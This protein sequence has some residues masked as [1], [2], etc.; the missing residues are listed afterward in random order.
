MAVRVRGAKELYRVRTIAGKA[1]VFSSK[2][3]YLGFEVLNLL[4]LTP[5]ACGLNESLPHENPADNQADDNE[6]DRHLDERETR[7]QSRVTR[8]YRGG[9]TS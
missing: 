2:S 9:V 4:Y 7:S 1:I 3:G 6:H 5:H 8:I